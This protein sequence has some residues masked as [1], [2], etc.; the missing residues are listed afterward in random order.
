VAWQP[1]P[2]SDDLTIPEAAVAISPHQYCVVGNPVAH[3]KSPQ[4]HAAFAAQTGQHI[5]Y[6]RL[7]APLAE[8]ERVVQDFAQSGGRGMNV[9]VPFKERAFHLAAI[10]GEAAMLAGAVNTLS[11]VDA[12]W[13]GDNTDGIGLL[14]DLT[15]NHGCPIAG[16]QILICGAGGAARG[17]LATLLRESPAEVVIA[18]RTSE[19]ARDLAARFRSCGAIA[20]AGYDG[21]AGRSFDLVINATALGLSDQ[22]PPLPE[23]VLA[24]DSW[25]YDL[26]YG[27]GPTAFQRWA[28][29]HGAAHALDGLGMLV[30]QAAESFYLWRGIRPHTAPVIA[31][32]RQSRVSAL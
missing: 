24:N 29:A 21:L 22:V 3:S 28:V 27:E 2:E 30:E 12:D 4:I 20:A 15:D 17:V 26:M 14:R 13:R 8:F 7:L 16:R 6:T 10:H 23:G 18:N 19:R 11:R 5:S 9:T 31:A 25:C 1:T 32:L